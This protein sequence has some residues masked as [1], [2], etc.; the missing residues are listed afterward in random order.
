MSA[1]AYGGSSGKRTCGVVGGELYPP[2]PRPGVCQFPSRSA[3]CWR[4]AADR[5]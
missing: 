2:V 1:L 3:A 5:P 4:F